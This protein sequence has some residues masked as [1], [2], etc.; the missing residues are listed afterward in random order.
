MTAE[1]EKSQTVGIE[2][3]LTGIDGRV[4]DLE[5]EVYGNREKAVIG[6]KPQMRDV[7]RLIERGKGVMWFMG[8]IGISNI[9][10]LFIALSGR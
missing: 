2:V 1:N 5:E 3:K 6:L 10:V 8:I 7:Q 9:V 4:V